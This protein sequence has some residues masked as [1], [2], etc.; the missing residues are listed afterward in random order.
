MGKIWSEACEHRK[1]QEGSTGGNARVGQWNISAQPSTSI[2]ATCFVRTAGFAAPAH[3]PHSTSIRLQWNFDG[4]H[5][6]G[7]PTQIKAIDRQDFEKVQ[8]ACAVGNSTLMELWFGVWGA[9]PAG[10]QVWFSDCSVGTVSGSSGLNNLVR[11]DGAPLQLRADGKLYDEG[12]DFDP[13][14]NPTPVARGYFPRFQ[15]SDQQPNV[16]LPAGSRLLP[17]Q[18][19]TIDYYQAG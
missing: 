13:I 10:S 8:V 14:D 3:G 18:D 11:R 2:L 5:R 12:Q 15:D 19:V 17:G 9:Q 16:T 6:C 7:N 4:M 1:G